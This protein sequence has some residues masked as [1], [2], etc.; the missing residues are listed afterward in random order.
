MPLL[1]SAS[2]IMTS[3]NL[4]DLDLQALEQECAGPQNFS[5]GGSD[6]FGP[7]AAVEEHTLHGSGVDFAS[8]EGDDC[9]LTAYEPSIVSAAERDW[10]NGFSDANYEG[11]A[12]STQEAAS[13][14][15]NWSVIAETRA[16]H[17][18]VAVG[19]HNIS[20]AVAAAFDSAGLGQDLELPWEQGVFGAIF[21]HDNHS[22]LRVF[23]PDARR[24]VQPSDLLDSSQTQEENSE[25]DRRV[26]RGHVLYKVSIRSAPD[27]S[28]ENQ[29]EID[30]DRSLRLWLATAHRFDWNCS[31]CAMIFE[32]DTEGKQLGILSDFLSGRSPDTLYKRARATNKICNWMEAHL[33]TYFPILQESEF[34]SFMCEERDDGAPTS[35]LKGFTE[36]VAFAHFVL[37]LVQ[38]EACVSSKRCNGVSKQLSAREVKQAPA[39]TVE[40]LLKLH[41]ILDGEELWDAALAGFILFLVYSRLRWS[42]GQHVIGWERDVLEDR[43]VYLE[44]KIGSHKTIRSAQHRFRFLPAA[45]I[46]HGVCGQDWVAKWLSVREQ[47]GM[48]DPPTHPPLAAPNKSGHPTSRP[49]SAQ[50]GTVWIRALFRRHLAETKASTHSA[51][52]TLLSWAAKRGFTVEDRL[53]LGYHSIAGTM[54]LTYSRDAAARGLRL[55]EGLLS[56]VRVGSFLP[57]MTRSGRFPGAARVEEPPLETSRV[58]PREPEVGPVA[59]VLAAAHVPLVAVGGDE[60]VHEGEHEEDRE[61]EKEESS[62]HAT[63]E[64]SGSESSDLNMP[65]NVMLQVPEAPVG[66]RFLRHRKTRMLHYTKVDWEH[67]L[68]CGR[69]I[70]PAHDEPVEIRYDSQVCRQCKKNAHI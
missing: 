27:I 44:A 54:A 60:E 12:G 59:A 6:G 55:L 67:F 19:N 56:E 37:G 10:Y 5:Q 7:A 9:N 53:M 25:A 14:S 41:G 18:G 2:R 36:A 58:H 61:E 34:Y 43:T 39:F 64:T 8:V 16:G 28:W 69:P 47:L 24:P 40:Q 49:V 21:G 38:L 32:G 46:G 35:R 1:P 52:A 48:A 45:A 23:A 17:D 65:N 42:D 3:N 57:D 4:V 68:A 51:K 31:L 62:S 30:W 15:N 11:D 63:T 66:F 29:K 20:R 33:T 26:D 50:E 22:W 70:G 13:S